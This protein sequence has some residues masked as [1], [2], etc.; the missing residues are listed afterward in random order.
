MSKSV[1]KQGILTTIFA[2][3]LQIQAF[4]LVTTCGKSNFLGHL[5]ARLPRYPHFKQQVYPSLIG[6][7]PILSLVGFCPFRHRKED[8]KNEY[9]MG[10]P[11]TTFP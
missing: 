1:L 4:S 11:S 7:F 9:R 8:Y 10:L 6:R 2:L 3:W 5:A